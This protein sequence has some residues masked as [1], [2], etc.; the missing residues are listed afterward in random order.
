MPP[1][2]PEG[3]S[4][5]AGSVSAPSLDSAPCSPDRPRANTGS[6]EK[7]RERG[8]GPAW[9]LAASPSLASTHALWFCTSE[10]R[11]AGVCPQGYR[12]GLPPFTEGAPASGPHLAGPTALCCQHCVDG[13]VPLGTARPVGVRAE[14]GG[15]P[16]PLNRAGGRTQVSCWWPP[17]GWGR[18]Q[19]LLA[20]K[21]QVAPPPGTRPPS[22]EAAQGAVVL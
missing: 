22:E 9:R 14:L 17:Q 3:I 4:L 7:V 12:G 16:H 6:T 15:S 11:E 13:D 10:G 21:W 5:R 20:E 2:R 1:T 8:L 18:C 19:T